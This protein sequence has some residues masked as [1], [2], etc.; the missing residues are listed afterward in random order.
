M[1]LLSNNKKGNNKQ[2]PGNNKNNNN[3]SKFIK[4]TSKSPNVAKKVRSSGVNRGS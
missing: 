2:Q 3:N 4:P 1:S